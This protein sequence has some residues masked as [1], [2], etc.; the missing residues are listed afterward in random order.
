[1]EYTLVNA[2]AVRN[3]HQGL[4]IKA[5]YKINPLD[6]DEISHSLTFFNRWP[7]IKI[8]A[9]VTEYKLNGVYVYPNGKRVNKIYTFSPKTKE[10][11]YFMGYSPQELIANKLDALTKVEE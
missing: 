4:M 10:G 11:V 6:P 5:Y 8:E 7:P 9:D 2:R 3:P 1:M